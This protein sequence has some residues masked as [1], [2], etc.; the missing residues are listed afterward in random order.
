MKVIKD[1]I[2]TLKRG[3]RVT[4]ELAPGEKLMSF[5]DDRF[6]RLGSQVDDVVTGDVI[7]SSDWVSWCSI[8]QRWIA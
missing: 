5:Y 6:Y 1:E 3:R 8:E 4:I 7:T 2:A